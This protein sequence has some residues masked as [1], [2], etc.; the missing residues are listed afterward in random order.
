MAAHSERPSGTYARPVWPW[1]RSAAP[2]RKLWLPASDVSSSSIVH[3]LFPSSVS[4]AVEGFVV[5]LHAWI[6][7]Y[8]SRV[9]DGDKT[10]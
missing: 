10:V 7:E 6:D 4:S 5:G 1:I 8:I 9:P 3:D 2:L